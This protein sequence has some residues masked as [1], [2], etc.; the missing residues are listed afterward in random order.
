MN[1]LEIIWLEDVEEKCRQKHGVSADEVRDFFN[2]NPRLKF[3]EKGE[4]KGFMKDDRHSSQRT[5][6]VPTTRPH[7]R[8]MRKTAISG[9]R[10]IAEIAEFW[11]THDFTDYEDRCP[12]V[13]EKVKINIRRVRHYVSIDP[14]LLRRVRGAARKRRM[15]TERLINLWIQ[16][17]YRRTLSASKR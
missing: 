6:R 2:E 11:D 10:T 5:Q 14:V 4:R 7:R 8:R 3:V 16:E 15:P 12:D 17:G 1:I 13:T 9:A